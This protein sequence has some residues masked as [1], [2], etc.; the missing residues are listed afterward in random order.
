MESDAL[1]A[2]MKSREGAW[3]VYEGNVFQLAF[4]SEAINAYYNYRDFVSRGADVDVVPA[5]SSCIPD[6]VLTAMT[7][8]IDSEGWAA[9]ADAIANVPPAEW[10]RFRRD[11]RR[12]VHTPRTRS[13][14]RSLEAVER[15]VQYGV[16]PTVIIK[17]GREARLEV[18]LSTSQLTYPPPDLVG[19]GSPPVATL[20]VPRTPS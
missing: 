14:R 12:L 20:I 13:Q 7:S 6:E 16:E 4:S 19:D 1:G 18:S 9:A 10:L 5:P 2:W 8:L 11:M 3:P 17:P 15:G